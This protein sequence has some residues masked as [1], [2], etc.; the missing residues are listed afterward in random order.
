[1][2]LKAWTA[3]VVFALAGCATIYNP[4]T[5]RRETVLSTDLERSL[6]EVARAQ[7]GLTSLSVGQVPPEALERVQA[8]GEGIA[9]VSDRQD[10]PYRFGVI[11]ADSLNA[12]TLPGGTIYVHTGLLEKADNEE[13]A[14]VLAHEVGHVAAR[15][16]AKHLQAGLGFSVLLSIANAAGASPQAV[17]L[18]DS[19][20]GLIEKG[21]S[22]Q[23]ELE[24][25][26]LAIR[27]TWRSGHD[28]AALGRFFEKMLEEHPESAADEALVW[29][30][31]HPLTRE[32]IRH[33]EAEI[34]KL[35]ARR[36]CPECGRSYGANA[37]FCAADGT[38][39]KAPRPRRGG[40][41]RS[42]TTAPA[43]IPEPV[44]ERG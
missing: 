19:L 18:T 36:F 33:A 35:S 4:A 12:F 40:K 39:L 25:D 8:I 23:D 5:G 2:R 16:V 11:Q 29:Q 24:A 22:R 15:H 6:G 31:T 20:Y 30:R 27:Y 1:M 26:R 7:M 14:A 41:G 42:K 13:L 17:R 43:A 38:A 28:P 10:L 21:F 32:R 44:E 3:L 9:R 34:E 37:E